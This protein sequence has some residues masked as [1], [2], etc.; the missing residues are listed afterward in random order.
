[1]RWLGF[2]GMVRLGGWVCESVI[3]NFLHLK[4]DADT[5][6]LSPVGAKKDT[7]EDVPLTINR[8]WF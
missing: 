2:A 8:T 4:V 5:Y 1:M 6:V 7:K 3:V